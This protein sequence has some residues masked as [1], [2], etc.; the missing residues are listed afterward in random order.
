M[1]RSTVVSQQML[2]EGWKSITAAAAEQNTRAPGG[3]SALWHR[4]SSAAYPAP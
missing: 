4:G 3:L 1:A 2:R